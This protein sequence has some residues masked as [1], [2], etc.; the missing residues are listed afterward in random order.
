MDAA[1][2]NV[3]LHKELGY[4]RSLSL[5]DECLVSYACVMAY[6]RDNIDHTTTVLLVLTCVHPVV[7]AIQ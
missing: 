5:F 6:L 1:I 3:S 7:L 2:Q 4:E